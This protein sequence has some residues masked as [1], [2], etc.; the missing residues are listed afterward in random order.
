MSRVVKIFIGCL[1]AE[2]DENEVH[3]YFSQYCEIIKIK[4][5]FRSNGICAGYGHFTTKI[6]KKNL[7]TLTTKNHFYKGRSLECRLYMKGKKLE[8]YLNDFNERRIYVRNI[9]HGTTDYE[10][11]DL[12]SSLCAVTRAYNANHVDKDGNVFG[13]VITK[14]PKEIE[15]LGQIGGIYLKGVKL[16]ISKSICHKLEHLKEKSKDSPQ[17]DLSKEDEEGKR[18][19]YHMKKRSLINLVNTSFTSF[20]HVGYQ[21]LRVNQGKK[22][23]LW[24]FHPYC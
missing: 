9:P 14:S 21:N 2:T 1:P 12:F 24:R 10:L 15:K 8:S 13:F 23:P 17:I 3:T 16:E 5:K 19:Q 7:K 4:I 22:A 20:E 18:G 11:Y 6:S